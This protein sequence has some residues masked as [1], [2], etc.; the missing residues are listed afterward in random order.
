MS[1]TT[2]LWL[3]VGA[4]LCMT[5]AG[6]AEVLSRQAYRR[7]RRMMAEALRMVLAYIPEQILLVE[8]LMRVEPEREET[9]QVARMTLVGQQEELQKLAARLQ[10]KRWWN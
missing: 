1:D 2:L 3:I 7:Q 5:I 8:D 6:V 4:L 10:T 9:L